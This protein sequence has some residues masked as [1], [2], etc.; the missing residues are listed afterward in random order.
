MRILF[1]LLIALSISSTLSSQVVSPPIY[2]QDS[3]ALV[4]LYDS[5]GGL[6]ANLSWDRND[7]VMTWGDNPQE[8]E[9]DNFEEGYRVVGINLSSKSL[10]GRLPSEVN[11]LEMLV[12]LNLSDNQIKALPGALVLPRLTILNVAGNQLS[13]MSDLSGLVNLVGLNCGNNQLEELPNL[14]QLVDLRSLACFLNPIVTLP[15]LD[16]LVNLENLDVCCGGKLESLP[17]LSRNTNL[18]RLRCFSNQLKELPSLDSLT[19]LD[20]LECAANQLTELPDLSSLANLKKLDCSRNY[21]IDLPDFSNLTN[22]RKLDCSNNL[23]NFEDIVPLLGFWN[24]NTIEDIDPD[25]PDGENVIVITTAGG[26]IYAPQLPIRAFNYYIT[27]NREITLNGYLEPNPLSTNVYQWTKAGAVVGDSSG[28]LFN[29]VATT[30]AGLYELEVRNPDAPD[31]VIK[32]PI[33]LVVYGPS[34]RI[35]FDTTTLIV[36]KSF[37]FDGSERECEC[38]QEGPT[39]KLLEGINDMIELNNNRQGSGSS[40]GKDTTEFN[41]YLELSPTVPS[42]SCGIFPSS[43]SPNDPAIAINQAKVGIVGT[44]IAPHDSLIHYFVR[45]ED[46]SPIDHFCIDN[47]QVSYDYVNNT[48]VIRAGGAHETHIAG[49][50]AKQLPSDIDLGIVDIKIFEK[51]AKLYDLICAIHFA[52]EANVDVLNLSLGYYAEELS[53]PLYEALEKAERQGVTVVVSSGNNG[54]N[55]S[56]KKRW[57]G[58]F[59]LSHKYGEDGTELNALSNLIVV[60]ALNAKQDS[61]A[62]FSNYGV[63]TVHIAAPGTGTM[64]TVVSENGKSEYTA[65]SGTSMAAAE[66]SRVIA[67]LKA[68]SPNLAPE[69]I[70]EALMNSGDSVK[71]G[72]QPIISSRKVNLIAAMKELNLT[73]ADKVAE[74]LEGL[75]LDISERKPRRYINNS[76][77]S[78]E[79]VVLYSRPRNRIYR[80]VTLEII[81]DP[82]IQ[83]VPDTVVAYG[84]CPFATNLH[85]NGL[86]DDGTLMDISRNY[87]A[88]VTA[89][90]NTITVFPAKIKID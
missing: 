2:V 68:Y 59:T 25:D 34:D 65:F 43:L 61:I 89:Q 37:L 78:R 90:G 21:L 51:D 19:Q 67:I 14:D 88:R 6:N 4:T 53:L 32:A 76:H 49:T 22:L 52:I 8:I 1:A 46:S 80:D 48:A 17:D 81:L 83:G 66:I 31:L 9:W 47:G 50:I 26:L 16:Q 44:G 84:V 38:V 60:A 55:N 77:P 28:L 15:D 82:Q 24:S 45:G 39:F 7:P 86:H 70:V 64:S 5:L 3:L 85:W 72:N 54:S 73:N 36:T 56:I 87:K 79:Q 42:I 12:N 74:E 62:D 58:N 30:D 20:S 35:P 75:M 40:V 71:V 57:P 41:Y 63:N 23:L 10:E 27:S 29:N 69:K 13:E 11:N 33:D 18:K